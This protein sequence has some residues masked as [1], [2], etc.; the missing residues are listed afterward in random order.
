M[1]DFSPGERFAVRQ[2]GAADYTDVCRIYMATFPCMDDNDFT[3]AWLSRSL[4]SSLAL[5]DRT[6]LR[7]KSQLIG[8]GIVCPH[9]ESDFP[10][11]RKKLWFLAVDSTVRGGGA[12]SVLLDSIIA[13]LLPGSLCLAPVNENRIIRWYEKKGFQIVRQSAFI[14]EDIPTC[15]MAHTLSE[16]SNDTITISTSSP[17]SSR[18]SSESLC[19]SPEISL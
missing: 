3:H 7:E 15:L 8:F 9:H 13:T 1:N 2:L 11:V 14:H 12:G 10:M 19:D 4:Q 5:L 18:R 17:L 6:R 16:D